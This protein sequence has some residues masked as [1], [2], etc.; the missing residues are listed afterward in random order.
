[1]HIDEEAPVAIPDVKHALV[2]LH[3]GPT[4]IELAEFHDGVAQRRDEVDTVKNLV[5]A[6]PGLEHDR[7]NALDLHP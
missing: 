6:G 7:A 2:D 4:F 5:L 3:L 1:V